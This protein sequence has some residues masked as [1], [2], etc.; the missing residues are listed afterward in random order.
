M[1][2]RAAAVLG[3]LRNEN[4]VPVPVPAFWPTT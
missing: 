2:K 3:V 4:I 1:E